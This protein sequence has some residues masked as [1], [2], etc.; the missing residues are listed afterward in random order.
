MVMGM[1]SPC[2]ETGFTS[3]AATDAPC[4]GG[5]GVKEPS[6]FSAS[7][8]AESKTDKQ[9]WPSSVGFLTGGHRLARK[10]W[11]A[12]RSLIWSVAPAGVGGAGREARPSLL[13]GQ[14][15][16]DKSIPAFNTKDRHQI[17]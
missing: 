10:T 16:S 17:S 2:G 12:T 14:F 9:S 1:K 3:I 8:I 5:E 11:E 4:A 6:D 13:R 15:Q 7:E